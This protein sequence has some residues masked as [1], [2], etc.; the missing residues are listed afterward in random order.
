[1]TESRLD[2]LRESRRSPHVALHQ[3]NLLRSRDAKQL[4]CVFEGADDVAF[5]DTIIRR[6]QG[7][8]RYLP[9][10]VNGKD[11][12]LGL[13][14]LLNRSAVHDLSLV[15][16]FVDKDFD[17]LKGHAPGPDLYCTPTYSVE[18]LMVDENILMALLQGE[19]RCTGAEGREECE[20]ISQLFRSHLEKFDRF[21]RDPNL[22]IYYARINRKRGMGIDDSILKYLDITLTDVTPRVDRAG[23][24]TLVAFS[25]PID[26]A[27]VDSAKMLFDGL[28]PGRDWRGKFLLGFFRKFLQLLK[29]DRTAPKQTCFKAGKTMRFE[30]HTDI[31]RALALLCDIPG[32]LKAFIEVF[33]KRAVA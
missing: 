27:Q 24:L 6:V 17:G 23:I 28:N 16:F 10:P 9:L 11:H 21:M 14:V 13:R 3:F 31:T 2:V 29:E 1:M 22:L 15:R 8:A 19:Y 20:S 25:D 33:P 7:D 12:V 5:F 30:A 32:C 4:I 26:W 18:N